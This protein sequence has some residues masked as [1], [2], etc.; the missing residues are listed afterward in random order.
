MLIQIQERDPLSE[1]P[2]QFSQE[3]GI[4]LG[5]TYSV[6][7][8]VGPK[9]VPMTLTLPF[10]VLTPSVVLENADG[11]CT[12]T[13]FDH[14]ASSRS[15]MLSSTKRHFD[16]PTT[17][18]VGTTRTP[19]SVA[20]DILTYLKKESEKILQK[21]ITHAVIT[22]PAYF[23]DAARSATQKAAMDAGFTV[24]RLI[25]EPTAA[26]LAYGL[27]QATQGVY[28]VFDLGGGTFDLSILKL[29]DHVFQVVATGGDMR[30]GGDDVD[31]A[32]CDALSCDT[33]TARTLK[34]QLFECDHASYNGVTLSQDQLLNLTQPLIHTMITI[35]RRVLRDAGMAPQDL[36]GIVLVGGSTRLHAVRRAVAD[37]FKKDPLTTINPDECVAHGAALHAHSLTA[38]YGA[39]VP[40]TS[41][42]SLAHPHLLLD[43]TPLSL[44]VETLGGI[45]DV[46]IPRNTPIPCHMAQDFTTA[47]DDQHALSLHIVQGDSDDVSACRSLGR[48]TLSNLP[49][50][51][52]HSVRVRVHFKL[53]ENG[54][55]TVSAHDHEHQTDAEMTLYS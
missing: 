7:A 39:L 41:S 19:V 51:P 30:L 34:E 27:D 35:T 23:D 29:V 50:G 17:P 16:A 42:D 24:M 25:A 52:A 44:G 1:K 6:V 40:P 54:L 22:V 46:I 5:T 28:A 48:L 37:F 4:D 21:P 2:V 43:V 33:L 9:G 13:R 10:G 26:A 38:Q 47:V 55:L 11:S 53:D 36:D 12:V 45:V 8:C 32:I 31:Q 20:T 14:G 49:K 3:V 15:R 18:L